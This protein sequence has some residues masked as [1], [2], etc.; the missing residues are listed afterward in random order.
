MVWGCE[1]YTG[2]SG[3]PDA[4]NSSPLGKRGPVWMVWCDCGYEAMTAYPPL[5]EWYRWRD[6]KNAPFGYLPGEV[7][8]SRKNV[9][10]IKPSARIG[11][12]CPLCGQPL[13]YGECVIAVIREMLMTREIE[14]KTVPVLSFG[15][16]SQRELGVMWDVSC[17]CGY[18]A[19]TAYHPK[20]EWFDAYERPVRFSDATKRAFATAVMSLPHEWMPNSVILARIRVRLDVPDDLAKSLFMA[21]VV[22]GYLEEQERP[23]GKTWYRKA[24]G[25]VDV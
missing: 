14:I 5:Q 7:W 8:D 15:E 3:S 11:A 10:A 4:V 23:D 17:D 22:M 16:P 24:G 25:P 13:V 1:V 9:T 18:K 21:A 19:W 6:A 20:Q 12:F 2:S